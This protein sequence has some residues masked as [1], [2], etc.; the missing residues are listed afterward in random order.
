MI[1]YHDHMV[2]TVKI[3]EH[4][5][6]TQVVQWL[7]DHVGA[8]VDALQQDGLSVQGSGWKWRTVANWLD[9][10][11]PSLQI[12]GRVDFDPHVSPD[13]ITQFMLTWS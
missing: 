6:C 8:R 13:L 3:A 2:I 11:Q 1:M 7:H 9:Y 12:S 5:H 4:A 10:N